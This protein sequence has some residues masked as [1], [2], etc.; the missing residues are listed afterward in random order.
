MYG[1]YAAALDDGPYV[2]C[3]GCGAMLLADEVVSDV[4]MGMDPLCD[5]CWQAA[6]DMADDAGEGQG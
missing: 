5:A 2:A 6:L 1:P 4:A 3:V